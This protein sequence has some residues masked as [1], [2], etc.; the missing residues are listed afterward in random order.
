MLF[1]SPMANNIGAERNANTGPFRAFSQDFA[2]NYQLRSK[3]LLNHCGRR[4]RALVMSPEMLVSFADNVQRLAE[5]YR[6]QRS[7]E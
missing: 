4:R 1:A 3:S 2:A 7:Q 6:E 5:P